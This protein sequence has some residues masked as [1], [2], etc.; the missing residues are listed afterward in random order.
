VYQKGLNDWYETHQAALAQEKVA[1]ANQIAATT[2]KV[3]ES[4]VPTRP[5]K[6]QQHQPTCR[7]TFS[8]KL[9]VL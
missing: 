7:Q 8:N 3:V 4:C 1:P 9:D 5:Q 2:V 6:T